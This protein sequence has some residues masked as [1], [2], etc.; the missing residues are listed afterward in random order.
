MP[1]I[2][3]L[4][5]TYGGI[6]F[7]SRLEARWA[8]FFDA[9]GLRFHYEPE[10]FALP[11]GI[12][13]LPDFWLPGFRMFL[14]VKPGE[15]SPAET[16]K[17]LGL[18][19]AG[20]ADVLLAMGPPEERANFLWFDRD[21]DRNGPR[22]DAYILARDH[23]SPAGFWLVPEGGDE[24]AY[25]LGPCSP[26]VALMRRGPMMTGAL[27]AARSVALSA[28]FRRIDGRRRVEPIAEA[29]PERLMA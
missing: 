6:K 22:D 10:G 28:D 18:A 12:A 11:G 25:H 16:A 17:A 23:Y 14:E 21:P 9:A 24:T 8:L 4:P 27:E 29:D 2:M 3:A 13:Y 1:D 5:T 19:Q 7:R 15:P 26:A 20:D